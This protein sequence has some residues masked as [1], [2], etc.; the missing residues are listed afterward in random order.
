[1]AQDNTTYTL[2][3]SGNFHYM[4]VYLNG[5]K[6][7]TSEPN[8]IPFG[9]NSCST[10]KSKIAEKT[11][12]EVGG[13]GFEGEFKDVWQRKLNWD[14]A[15]LR[16]QWAGEA[17]F[18]DN[19]VKFERKITEDYKYEVPSCKLPDPPAS[20]KYTLYP[21]PQVK[22]TVQSAR[23]TGHG[24]QYQLY[25]TT[26]QGSFQTYWD[27][28][29]LGL[30]QR[31]RDK[32]KQL[33][34][35][36]GSTCAEQGSALSTGS[37][38]SLK[39]SNSKVPFTCQLNVR[40]GGMR[41]GSCSNGVS[42][43]LP[44]ENPKE[45]NS[46][47]EFK[48]VDPKNIFPQGTVYNGEQYARNW[49]TGEQG[50]GGWGHTY[51]EIKNVADQDKTYAPEH[52]TYSFKLDAT[53]L[54]DIK[55]YNK[56]HT[57]EEFDTYMSCTC[58]GDEDDGCGLIKSPGYPTPGGSCGG[59]TSWNTRCRKCLSNGFLQVAANGYWNNSDKS[60]GA[61]RSSSDVHWA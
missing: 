28:D 7:K 9:S 53:A 20:N 3:P 10:T 13:G 34:N 33:F 21:G 8:M 59:G 24:H 17:F 42:S 19:A 36:N 37:A 22:D 14:A 52:L 35:Q 45:I 39:S 58:S 11:S 5:Q 1:M 55:R 23:S 54:N 26:Y 27:M 47:Y 30:T 38:E 51:Y 41:I 49:R 31:T 25:L 29:G 18:N 15:L 60:L 4:Q 6:E 56:N 16:N 50:D 40:L 43:S 2:N 12:S 57:Y 32:F 61:V 48:V 46:L 44:C